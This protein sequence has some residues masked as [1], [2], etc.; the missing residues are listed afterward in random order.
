LSRSRID[1]RVTGIDHSVTAIALARKRNV[2]HREAGTA[3]LEQVILREFRS[4]SASRRPL[5]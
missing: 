4:E 5:A 1:G 3:V 2:H